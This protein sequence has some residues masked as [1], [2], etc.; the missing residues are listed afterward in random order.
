[1]RSGVHGVVGYVG[2]VLG[3][4]FTF[5]IVQMVIAYFLHG[6]LS[7]VHPFSTRMFQLF[8][9]SALM[10]LLVTFC[11]FFTAFIPV[12]VVHKIADRYSITNVGYYL[13]CGI[14]VGIVLAPIADLITPRMFTAPPEEPPM[15]MRILLFCRF[16]VPGGAVGGLI[17]WWLTGRFLK[18]DASISV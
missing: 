15:Y 6:G 11:V 3:A 12:M 13:L 7:A 14:A 9:M 4:S 10:F 1:M 8:T 2:A 16:S 5:V 17:Y 18:R